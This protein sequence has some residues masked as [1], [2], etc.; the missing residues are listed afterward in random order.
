MLVLAL[1]LMS[2]TRVF[3]LLPDHFGINI[4]SVENIGA[5][6]AL[7][8]FFVKI[9]L[10]KNLNFKYAWIAI[11]FIILA[12]TSSIQGSRLY[13]GQTIFDGLM[14]QKQYIA[15]VLAFFP[16]AT[17]I[18][19]G[20]LQ[21]RDIINIL[22]VYAEIQM[23]LGF[24]QYIV[25]PNHQFMTCYC[26]TPAI[27]AK[28]HRMRIY[29]SV[30]YITMSFMNACGNLLNGH[31]KNR[32]RFY[33]ALTLIYTIIVNQGRGYLM[34][35]L[36]ALFVSV[37]LDKNN[38]NKKIMLFPI[39]ILGIIMVLKS[40][41]VQ[42]IL[43]IITTTNVETQ[44]TFAVRLRSQEFYRTILQKNILLGGGF[45]DPSNDAANIASG[46]NLGLFVVD[47]GFWGYA[48]RFGSVGIIVAIFMIWSDIKSSLLLYRTKNEYFGFMLLVPILVGILTEVSW[49]DGFGIL[50]TM[51][52]FVYFEEKNRSL[53]S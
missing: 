17:S 20:K 45:P 16:I 44:N 25:G 43:Y 47:N 49:F 50:F 23:L 52:Y 7:I 31:E 2:V 40:D 48:F 6:I 27:D 36:V 53:I 41:F 11:A 22:R 37:L 26:T 35:L 33:V 39:I 24:F 3:Y 42:N 8:W 19:Q 15:C 38:P 30:G 4:I 14:A 34:I 46:V 1:I 29:G 12:V 21:W 9:P 13:S 28:V 32:N 5:L 51:L 10:Y 18:K